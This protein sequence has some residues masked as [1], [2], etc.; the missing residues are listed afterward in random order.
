MISV[1]TSCP[2]PPCRI[3]IRCSSSPTRASITAIF[4]SW[5]SRDVRPDRPSSTARA[6]LANQRYISQTWNR[7]FQDRVRRPRTAVGRCLTSGTA[8]FTPS[9]NRTRKVKTYVYLFI[10]LADPS[11]HYNVLC[12]SACRC[13]LRLSALWSTLFDAPFIVS[14]TAVVLITAY[15]IS[16]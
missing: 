2:V 10:L 13:R 14:S 9:P 6:T 12:P 3:Q 11:V 15:R 16:D 5:R 8:V 4:R 1:F 7:I